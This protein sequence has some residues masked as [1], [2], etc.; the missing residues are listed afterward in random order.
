MILKTLFGHVK[1]PS[2]ILFGFHAYEMNLLLHWGQNQEHY[3]VKSSHPACCS[4]FIYSI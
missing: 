2:E 4:L 1:N 3:K